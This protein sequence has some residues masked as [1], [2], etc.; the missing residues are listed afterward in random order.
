MKAFMDKDFLLVS[1]QAHATISKWVIIYYFWGL[2]FVK[3]FFKNLNKF[4]IY[5]YVCHIYYGII[6]LSNILCFY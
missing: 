5:D 6:A 1:R 4:F 3:K 2:Q